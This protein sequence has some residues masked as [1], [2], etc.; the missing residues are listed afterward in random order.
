MMTFLIKPYP[1]CHLEKQETIYGKHNDVKIAA[2]GARSKYSVQGEQ[3]LGLSRAGAEVPA[4]AAQ[5]LQ[6]LRQLV[7][8]IAALRSAQHAR[9]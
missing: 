9:V 7:L 4:G 8:R 1:F 6:L 3:D 5:L 2:F